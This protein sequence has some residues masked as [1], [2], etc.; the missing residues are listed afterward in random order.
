MKRECSG[1]SVRKEMASGAPERINRAGDVCEET[2]LENSDLEHAAAALGYCFHHMRAT[3]DGR[4]E[5]G[6]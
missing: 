2:F 3:T 4:R 6:L 1:T 5:H